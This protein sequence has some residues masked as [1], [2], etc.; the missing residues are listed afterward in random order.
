MQ[1]HQPQAQTSQPSTRSKQ[2]GRATKHDRQQSRTCK[3]T[4][5]LSTVCRSAK[6]VNKIHNDNNSDSDGQLGA[7][8]MEAMTSGDE[9]EPW[10]T[11]IRINDFVDMQFKLDTGVD[12]TVNLG[13]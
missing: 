10:I 9:A 7:V 12:V 3:K 2:C 13:C 4:D 1:S 6:S 5:H 11:T 8:F